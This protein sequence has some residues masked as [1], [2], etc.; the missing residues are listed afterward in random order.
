MFRHTILL[1]LS[2]ALLLPS[3]VLVTANKSIL[4]LFNS[5]FVA[6]YFFFCIFNSVFYTLVLLVLLTVIAVLLCYLVN[7]FCFHY[8]LQCLYAKFNHLWYLAI[9]VLSCFNSL[10]P[11][12][13]AGLHLLILSLNTYFLSPSIITLIPSSSARTSNSPISAG[14]IPDCPDISILLR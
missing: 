3:L 12:Y 6:F 10:F 4:C 8:I 2:N 13:C 14:A 9:W 7:L 1:L 11:Y 5:A